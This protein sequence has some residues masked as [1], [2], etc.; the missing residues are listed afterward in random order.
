LTV[1]TTSLLGGAYRC[2][3]KPGTGTSNPYYRNIGLLNTYE[4]V[5]TGATVGG[6]P[7]AHRGDNPYYAFDLGR[8]IDA[9]EQVHVVYVISHEQGDQMSL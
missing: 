1:S 5:V 2:F 6:Q 7:G 4:K 9:S 3:Y 8:P